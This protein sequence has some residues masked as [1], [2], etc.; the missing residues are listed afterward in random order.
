MNL[1]IR[2]ILVSHWV[3][4][5]RLSIHSLRSSVQIRGSMQKLAGTA[6][7]LTPADMEVL[8]RKIK[9]VAGGWFVK[10]ELDNWVLNEASG[11]WESTAAR[12]GRRAAAAFNAQAWSKA[13]DIKE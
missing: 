4:L 9:A 10:M 1:E 7:E 13:Y 6:S 5:G 3:D 11:S 12:E 8:Y 2:R